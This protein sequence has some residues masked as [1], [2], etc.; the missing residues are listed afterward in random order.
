MPTTQNVSRG[1]RQALQVCGKNLSRASLLPDA[2]VRVGR[3]RGRRAIF[4]AER[5]AVFQAADDLLSDN[6]A[7]TPTNVAIRIQPLKVSA[8]ALSALLRKRR[9]LFGRCTEAWRQTGR[10]IATWAEHRQNRDHGLLAVP[11]YQIKPQVSWFFLLPTF[12]NQVQALL[13]EPVANPAWAVT[14]DATYKLKRMSHVVVMLSAI[15]HRSI[16]GRWRRSFWPL[17]MGCAPGNEDNF[18][19]ARMFDL[20]R[21]ELRRRGLPAPTQAHTDWFAGFPGLLQE[22]LPHCRLRQ[23]I[24]HARRSMSRNHAQGSGQARGVLPRRKRH[25]NRRGRGRGRGGR[26][27]RRRQPAEG[28]VEP[29]AQGAE[30]NAQGEGQDPAPLAVPPHLTSRPLAAFMAFFSESIFLPTALT[31]HLFWE[32][33]RSRMIDGWGEAAWTNYFFDQYLKR[34]NRQGVRMWTAS[35]HASL[36]STSSSEAGLPASQQTAEQ[37]W[38]QL[39]RSVNGQKIKTHLDLMEAMEKVAR[40]WTQDVHARDASAD[41]GVHSLMPCGPISLIRPSQPDSWMLQNEGRSLRRPGGYQCY[42]P[43]VPTIVEKSKVRG[44]A[45][46]QR[47]RLRSKTILVMAMGRQRAVPIGLARRMHAQITAHTVADLRQMWLGEGFIVEEGAQ[48]ASQRIALKAYRS[49]W[50]KWCLVV[51]PDEDITQTR[52]TCWCYAWH[53]QCPHAWAGQEITGAMTWTRSEH[54]RLVQAADLEHDSE[55]E[56]QPRR[57]RRR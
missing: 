6:L 13:P 18:L 42:M 54:I 14:I 39:K 44:G 19:Y 49:V 21:Q 20:F 15:V 33:M 55:Q 36:A 11:F 27:R 50:Q 38:K 17:L 35:W 41:R 16:G 25:G 30:G 40:H 37:A 46:V 23:G 7:A 8:S 5:T 22:H 12:F 1:R 53:G 28:P 9:R 45:A 26:Q 29:D 43:S 31:F 52:C 4:H 32:T 3:M 48:P 57:K 2:G 47:L 10:D 34:V 51:V 24:E 56:E